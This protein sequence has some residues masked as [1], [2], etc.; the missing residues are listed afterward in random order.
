MG[1]RIVPTTVKATFIGTLELMIAARA[2]TFFLFLGQSIACGM[3]Q[4]RA[5][6]KL[7]L[8]SAFMIPTNAAAFCASGCPASGNHSH[9]SKGDMKETLW[10]TTGKV[11]R[12]R[13]MTFAA[14]VTCCARK[15]QACDDFDRSKCVALGSPSKLFG[16]PACR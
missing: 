5:G 3:L 1:D 8:R 12:L 14:S 15:K 9:W 4:L 7:H 2:M 13:K 16:Y 6:G 11:G 10:Q